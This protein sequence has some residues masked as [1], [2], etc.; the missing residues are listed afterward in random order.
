MDLT[1]IMSEVY[2]FHGT[3]FDPC[4]KVIFINNHTRCNHEV[5]LSQGKG[6][7]KV[8]IYRVDAVTSASKT[9]FVGWYYTR[10]H[11]NHKVGVHLAML[12]PKP[13]VLVSFPTSNDP[14][15]KNSS[16]NHP[17]CANTINSHLDIDWWTFHWLGQVLVMS[18]AFL[19]SSNLLHKRAILVKVVYR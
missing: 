8:Y 9:C 17:F 10:L 15:R 14:L 3:H 7:N 19:A 11:N 16:L 4:V 5:H 12:L 2:K 13:R 18:F 1:E 6:M